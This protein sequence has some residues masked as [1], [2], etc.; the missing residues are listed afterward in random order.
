MVNQNKID[1]LLSKM[2]KQ[3]RDIFLYKAIHVL[4]LFKDDPDRDKK[5]KERV[6]KISKIYPR[7]EN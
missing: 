2:G 7:D 1:H 4:F 5:I 6:S 3:E